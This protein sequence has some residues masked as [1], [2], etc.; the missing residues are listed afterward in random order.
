MSRPSN[1]EILAACE[2]GLM[3][4]TAEASWLRA[5]VAENEVKD[6]LI[7]K[8]SDALSEM[9]SYGQCNCGHPACKRCKSTKF[10]NEVW[11]EYRAASA[12][13]GE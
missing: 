1:A 6:A 13:K 8:L 7:E 11:A 9:Y 5:L 2:R 12:G 10:A 4:G 3:Q